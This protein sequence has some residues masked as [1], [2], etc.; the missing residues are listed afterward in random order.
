MWKVDWKGVRLS[1]I[2]SNNERKT[3]R[4]REAV[5]KRNKEVFNRTVKYFR[6]RK[7]CSQYLVRVLLRLGKKRKSVSKK[8]Y[9]VL[10]EI[11]KIRKHGDNYKVI[12]KNPETNAESTEWFSVENLADL[13]KTPK[14]GKTETVNE[15]YRELLKPISRQNRY[16]SFQEQRFQVTFHP[17]GDGNCQISA[18][19][20]QMDRLGI[21]RSTSKVREEIV[22]Y[23]EENQN[24][25][26][27]GDVPGY[28]I[29]SVSTRD[30]CWWNLWRRVN[31]SSETATG[32]VLLKKVLLKISQIHRK[33][34]ASEYLF[35][36]NTSG[37]LLLT[38]YSIKHL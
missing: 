12:F 19:A 26:C 27:R 30:D 32:G 14:K 37:R 22:K 13:R 17:L 31:T 28:F 8:Y 38:S 33:T 18:T 5:K 10:G 15:K 35:L 21:H 36:Q 20:H 29:Q 2:I 3:L 9:V 24:E 4:S 11:T 1:E 7:K 23:L 34:P 6:Q 16:E 25:A